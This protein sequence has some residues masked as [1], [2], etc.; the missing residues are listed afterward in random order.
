MHAAWVRAIAQVSH[1][2]PP[3]VEAMRLE[4]WQAYAVK[5]AT[6]SA[7]PETENTSE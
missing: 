5:V 1:H 2:I 3:G 6:I 4:P 7:I